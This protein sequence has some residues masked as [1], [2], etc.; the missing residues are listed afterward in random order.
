M[1]LKL[2]YLKKMATVIIIIFFFPLRGARGAQGE[3]QKGEQIKV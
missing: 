2:P 3:H 1:E